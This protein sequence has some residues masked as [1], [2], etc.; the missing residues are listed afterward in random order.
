MK[1]KWLLL[2]PLV[3]AL[4]LIF[5]MVI[6]PW[7]LSAKDLYGSWQ[8]TRNGMVEIYEFQKRGQGL[9]RYSDESGSGTSAFTYR[10]RDGELLISF[11]PSSA[12]RATIT[13]SG[14]DLTLRFSEDTTWH[15]TRYY[16]E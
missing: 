3:L 2:V 8:T 1:N 12:D 4:T 11:G 13:L 9:L 7:K 15:L 6:Q 5:L 16:P 14:D 10:V